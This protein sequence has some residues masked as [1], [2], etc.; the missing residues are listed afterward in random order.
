MK[1]YW[2][3]LVNQWKNWWSYGKT[4]MWFSLLDCWVS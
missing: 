1:I 3:D 4:T 2:L